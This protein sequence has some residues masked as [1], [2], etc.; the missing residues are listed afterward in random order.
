MHRIKE[1]QIFS[2]LDGNLS[3]NKTQSLRKHLDSCE[4]CNNYLD[5]IK[6]LRNISRTSLPQYT[7]NW[8]KIEVVVEE[9]IKRQSA[10]FRKPRTIIWTKALV[11]I[12][13]SMLFVTSVVLALSINYF[14]TKSQKL[15]NIE[16]HTKPNSK[17]YK[18][19]NE[20]TLDNLSHEKI[21]VKNQNE[22]VKKDKTFIDINLKPNQFKDTNISTSSLK[23]KQIKEKNGTLPVRII[24]KTLNKAKPKIQN[25]YEN[26]LKRNPN[27]ILL[28]EINISVSQKGFVSKVSTNIKNNN[29]LKK[30]INQSIH[31]LSFPPPK[32]GPLDLIFPLRLY[33]GK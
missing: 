12:A 17:T 28:L 27:L 31:S 10:E 2:L 26:A 6:H 23:E 1:K 29:L 5:N 8:E 21:A 9:G 22:P 15:N 24:N 32:G 16:T 20:P 25:C 33:P 14:E 13:I 4:K 19:I 18:K 11:P 3:E 7:P 30:C